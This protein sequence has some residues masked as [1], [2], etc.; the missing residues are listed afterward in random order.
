M[1]TK[2]L[3]KKLLY[4][5]QAEYKRQLGDFQGNLDLL[6]QIAERYEAIFSGKL[7]QERL[8]QIFE[9]NYEALRRAA[10]QNITK[11]ARNEMIAEVSVKLF[12]DKFFDFEAEV[13]RL[14]ERFRKTGERQIFATFTPLQWY[15]LNSEGRFFLPDETLELIRERCKNYISSP[16]EQEIFN[17]LQKVSDA[18]NE[19][20][21]K[22]GL[23]ARKN[24]ESNFLPRHYNIAEFLIA[25]ED[26][27][28]I[29]D[30]QINYK[31]LIS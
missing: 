31:A 8:T 1:E 24:L 3:E 15:S 17:L 18:I 13:S 29:P 11:A 16:E 25:D 12:L 26:G 14:V 9:G 5:D 21:E 2:T 28:T 19:A 6:N 20:Y 27:K 23:N 10:I 4:F 30:P 22:L 7:I